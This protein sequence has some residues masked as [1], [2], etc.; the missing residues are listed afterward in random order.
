M[1]LLK[2][3]LRNALFRRPG[4]SLL[5]V[6][7]VALAVLAFGM[8]RTVVDAWYAG[9]ELS[10]AT[11]LVTRNSI[12]LIFT[13]PL[14]YKERIRAVPGVTTVAAANWF[15]GVY[16]DPKN[17]IAIFA[18][19][20]G[21]YFRLYP[22][23]QIPDRQMED[24][25]RDRQGCIAG[26]K[27]AKRFGW[28]VG[29]TITIQ[30][31]IYPGDWPMTVRGIYRGRDKNIDETQLIF[32]WEYLNETMKKTAP[33]RADQVGFYM[34]GIER[35]ELAAEISR[36]IDE[37]F[38]NSLAETLTE[39]EKAFQLGFVAMSSAII[40]AIRTVSVMVIF[41]IMA[42]AANTMAMAARERLG[43]FA[44]LKTLGFTPGWLSL[45]MLGESLVVSLAGG[46]LGLLLTFPA[47]RAFG[48][49]MSDFL[50]VFDVSETTLWLQAAITLG[51][52]LAAA[53]FPALR[54]GRAPIA[55]SLRR[56]A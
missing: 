3:V 39:T 26:R 54:A 33:R 22:E 41:I 11:R 5:T 44:A 38:A 24:F 51:V 55:E 16:Q 45:L 23:Y 18:V 8:L 48:Q 53:A 20:D 37:R 19:E 25:H 1:L 52:G 17:F 2:L 12:S 28:K 34:V 7:G 40:T 30:G 49:A 15:G 4:R 50:P 35:P 14:A 21:P 36:N 56:I 32:H 6:A 47:A 31:N 29:D 46:G 10:S 13:L 9:V 43:E 42:V 27:L